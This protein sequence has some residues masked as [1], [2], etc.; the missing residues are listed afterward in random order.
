MSSLSRSAAAPSPSVNARWAEASVALTPN[1]AERVAIA[2]ASSIARSSC[3]PG[4]AISWI[5]PIRWASAAPYSS[6][7]SSQRI[8]LPQPASR[9]SRIVAPPNG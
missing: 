6:P 7:V 2:C 1:G 3:S 9:G 4:S 5:R 8:A